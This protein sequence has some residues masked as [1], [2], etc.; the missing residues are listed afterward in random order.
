MK[1]D[2]ETWEGYSGRNYD[3]WVY[4]LD[5]NFGRFGAV[6]IYARH[7]ANGPCKMLYVNQTDRLDLVPKN[8]LAKHIIETHEPN[9]IQFWKCNKIDDRKT[10]MTDLIIKHKPPGNWGES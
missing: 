10:V 7:E 9:C 4:D 3:F 8:P 5:K 2:I 1:T 6:F